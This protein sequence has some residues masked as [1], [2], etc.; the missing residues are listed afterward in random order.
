MTTSSKQQGG[1]KSWWPDELVEATNSKGTSNFRR[2]KNAE[3]KPSLNKSTN[4]FLCDFFTFGEKWFLISTSS[5]EDS[6]FFCLGELSK[7]AQW[8][9]IHFPF[10]AGGVKRGEAWWTSQVSVPTIFWC[11]QKNRPRLHV[12]HIYGQAAV[13]MLEK[14]M[15]ECHTGCL[16]C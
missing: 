7:N 14:H 13:K 11:Q 8:L 15:S 3:K 16:H 12:A 4:F 2:P 9:K 10:T 5:K 1:F 6:Y